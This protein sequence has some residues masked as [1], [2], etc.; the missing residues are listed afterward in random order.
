MNC[1]IEDGNNLNLIGK[2]KAFENEKSIFSFD[3]YKAEE[4]V[5]N[6]Y[7]LKKNYTDDVNKFGAILKFKSESSKNIFPQTTD[8]KYIEKTKEKIDCVLE[9]AFQDPYSNYTDLSS[10]W[11]IVIPLIYI[12]TTICLIFFYCKYRRIN[13]N[14]DQLR[15]EVEFSNMTDRREDSDNNIN[16]D[17]DD[18][19]ENV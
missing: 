12:I 8:K 3:T 1:I 13:Y 16:N 2:N 7:L 5:F 10:S 17:E 19:I 4:L 15:Q 9:D 18:D 14:Y 11:L 6:T